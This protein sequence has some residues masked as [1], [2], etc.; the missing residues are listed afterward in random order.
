MRKLWTFIHGWINCYFLVRKMHVS[1]QAIA[2]V[3][4]MAWLGAA[5]EERQE[6]WKEELKEEQ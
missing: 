6:K 4:A 3:Q 1:G 2:Q 5:E